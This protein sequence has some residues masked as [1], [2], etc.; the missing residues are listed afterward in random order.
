MQTPT[1]LQLRNKRLMIIAVFVSFA[2][3]PSLFGFTLTLSTLK[4]M[5][6]AIVLDTDIAGFRAKPDAEGRQPAAVK[7]KLQNGS[8]LYSYEE[9]VPRRG[10]KQEI[11]T[12]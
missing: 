2:V 5:E 12:A 3:I 8:S 11:D 9:G 1:P 10:L 7:I 6:T 4:F